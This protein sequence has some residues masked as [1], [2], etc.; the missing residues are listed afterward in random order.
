MVLLD[1]LIEY[2]R[3]YVSA[4]YILN[5]TTKNFLLSEYPENPDTEQK[6]LLIEPYE[7]ILFHIFQKAIRNESF[8]DVGKIKKEFGSSLEENYGVSTGYFLSLARS[9]WTFKLELDELRRNDYQLTIYQ[10]LAS[11]EFEIASRFFPTPGPLRTPN[12]TRKLTQK[13][14]LKKYAPAVNINDYFKSNP[15]FNS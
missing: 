3:A 5:E 7:A 14:F 2:N 15:Y 9:Y 11:A 1:W 4:G 10:V 8:G 12:W 13:E 6:K